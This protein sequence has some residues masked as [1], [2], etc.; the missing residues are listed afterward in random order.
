MFERLKP[1]AAPYSRRLVTESGL[2][3]PGT[4][5]PAVAF[6]LPSPPMGAS[7]L[8]SLSL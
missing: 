1:E 8:R 5:P 2:R 3:N 7:P 4:L 6:I